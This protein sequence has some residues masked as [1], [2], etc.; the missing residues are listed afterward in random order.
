MAFPHLSQKQLRH[1]CNYSENILCNLTSNTIRMRCIVNLGVM[2]EACPNWNEST[3]RLRE[4]HVGQKKHAAAMCRFQQKCWCVSQHN[5]LSVIR[6]TDLAA[7]TSKNP[8]Q[9]NILGS[10]RL[11]DSHKSLL[12]LCSFSVQDTVSSLSQQIWSDHFWSP[13][14]TLLTSNNQHSSIHTSMHIKKK[15]RFYECWGV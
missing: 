8:H 9:I 13:L 10:N 12:H 3:C 7:S 6:A 4:G 2:F 15:F 1:P 14:L 11:T 5:A